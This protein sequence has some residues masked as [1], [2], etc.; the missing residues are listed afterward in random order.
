M[1]E[2]T[3]I[4]TYQLLFDASFTAAT[5]TATA[6]TATATATTASTSFVDGC[7]IRCNNERLCFVELYRLGLSY[8]ERQRVS[9]VRPSPRAPPPLLLTVLDDDHA[10]HD[11]GDQKESSAFNHCDGHRCR[12]Q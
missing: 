11:Q 10:D 12:R 9:S 8:D 1:R 3:E 4:I 5:T 6:T 2:E 7:L